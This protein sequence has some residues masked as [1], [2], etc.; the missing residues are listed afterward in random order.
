[1]QNDDKRNNNCKATG[2]M[3]M[4]S[5]SPANRTG[6]WIMHGMIAR[7]QS[8]EPDRAMMMSMMMPQSSKPRRTID[9][10]KHAQPQSSKLDRTMR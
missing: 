3:A 8:S 5:L 6:P 1:M 9:D 4:Q 2:P 7:P 10:A